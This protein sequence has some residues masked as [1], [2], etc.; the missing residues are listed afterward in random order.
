[1]NQRFILT[2]L[3]ITIFGVISAWVVPKKAPP[4]DTDVGGFVFL[5]SMLLTSLIFT[6]YLW[7]HLL[8]RISRLFTTYLCVTEKSNWELDFRDFRDGPYLSHTK[9]Q[10]VVYMFLVILGTIFPLLICLVFNQNLAPLPHFLSSMAVGFVYLLL[11]FGMGFL[12]WWDG[13]QEAENR[14][15]QL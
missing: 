10:T 13:E 15:K 2:T 6:L 5:A 7:N 11:M 12:N 8:K 1:M 3:A 14:W 9:P 4:V